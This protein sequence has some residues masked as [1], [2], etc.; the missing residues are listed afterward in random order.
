M[1][2]FP[3]N[4]CTRPLSVQVILPSSVWKVTPFLP[5]V[6]PNPWYE[7]S[8]SHTPVSHWH[9]TTPTTILKL[10]MY[11][12]YCTFLSWKV[13]I[14]R[15]GVEP[16]N[17]KPKSLNLAQKVERINEKSGKIRLLSESIRGKLHTLLASGMSPGKYSPSG[18]SFTMTNYVCNSILEPRRPRNNNP[19]QRRETRHIFH[20]IKGCH[21]ITSFHKLFNS[22]PL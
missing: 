12:M 14:L 7:I 15:M 4:P 1:H 8:K 17:Q 19:Y 20:L 6:E 3:K 2:H 18:R 11:K 16:S 9:T 5:T 21:I 10:H 13:L 22:D